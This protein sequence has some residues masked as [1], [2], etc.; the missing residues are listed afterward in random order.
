MVSALVNKNNFRLGSL[1]VHQRGAK[2]KAW[3][4]AKISGVD[5]FCI[6]A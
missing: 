4:T 2:P 6:A 3:G 5:S 1:K